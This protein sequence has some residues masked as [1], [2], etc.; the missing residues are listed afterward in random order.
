MNFFDRI[1]VAACFNDGFKTTLYLHWLLDTLIVIHK[2]LRKPEKTVN[3]HSLNER[4][5]V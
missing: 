1:A 5:Y 4:H 3:Y 2:R